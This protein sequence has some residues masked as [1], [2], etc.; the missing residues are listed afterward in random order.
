VKPTPAVG[1]GNVLGLV[2]SSS[3]QGLALGQQ[4]NC[5]ALTGEGT[6]CGEVLTVT[7]DGGRHW[8]PAKL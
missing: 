4:P 7:T 1:V 2:F 3:S 8:N 6:Y 5:A